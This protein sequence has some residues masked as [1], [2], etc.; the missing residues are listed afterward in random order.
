[1][2]NGSLDSL[3]ELDLNMLP[4]LES[5]DLER[6]Q[7]CAW[8]LVP[9]NGSDKIKPGPVAYHTSVVYRDQMFLFGGNNYEKTVHM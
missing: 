9:Q 8:R 3:W 2:R 7:N 5:N 6:R 4:D 1:M